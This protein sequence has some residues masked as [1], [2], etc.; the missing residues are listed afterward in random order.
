MGVMDTVDSSATA[1]SSATVATTL[2]IDRGTYR[3]IRMMAAMEEKSSAQWM[4]EALG[5]VV[6][7]IEEQIGPIPGA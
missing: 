4:R 6:K 3:K 1:D 5:L 2:R 7:K